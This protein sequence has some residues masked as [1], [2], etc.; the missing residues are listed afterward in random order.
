MWTEKKNT[1]ENEETSDFGQ[2]VHSVI[3][4]AMLGTKM[5]QSN[6]ICIYARWN[7]VY[8]LAFRP[9]RYYIAERFGYIDFSKYDSNKLDYITEIVV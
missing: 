4:N 1:R 3:L 7:T 5:Y 8:V 6:V 2:S 9:N